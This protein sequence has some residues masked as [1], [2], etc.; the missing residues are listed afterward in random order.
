MGNMAVRSLSGSHGTRDIMAMV[1]VIMAIAITVTVTVTDMD[2]VTDKATGNIT[3]KK[4]PGI[5]QTPGGFFM[6]F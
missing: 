1:I 5:E 4:T 6:T 2:M 3:K